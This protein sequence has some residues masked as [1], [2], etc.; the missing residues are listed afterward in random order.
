M[1]RTGLAAATAEV[2]SRD[3]ALA[4]LIARVGPISYPPRGADG[5]FAALVRAIVFQ[6]L[7]GR[8][9]QAI[10]GRV[11]DTVGG[12]LSAS[13]IAAA[14]DESLRAAGLSGNKLAAL[15]DLSRRDLAGELMLHP[16]ARDSDDSIVDSLVR[17]RGIG[18]WTAEMFLLF[19]LRRL[20]VW[21]VDDLGVRQGY[22]LIF[23][24]SPAPLAK[25]LAPLGDRFR[26]YR[27]VVAR[28]C[29][30]AVALNRG[31]D[32]SLR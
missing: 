21:P 17:V 5:P 14:T 19:E 32:A 7:A 15:R 1:A 10:L 2:A 20:D 18:R 23:G 6:Q 26:P 4:R 16:S 29:W 22:G 31:T 27:S 12:V 8:A 9:A 25:Q 30:E 3:P 24:I 13:A 28:Y 11:V